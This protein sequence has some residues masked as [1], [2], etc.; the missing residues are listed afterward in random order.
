[1]STLLRAWRVVCRARGRPWADG[2]DCTKGPIPSST[3]HSSPLPESDITTFQMVGV[4]GFRH[5]HVRRHLGHPR[6]RERRLPRGAPRHPNIVAMPPGGGDGGGGGDCDALVNPANEALQGTRFDPTEANARF[7]NSGGRVY[8]EQ[9]GRAVTAG[10]AA[11]Y[12]ACQAV[13]EIPSTG[14]GVRCPVG[15]AVVTPARRVAQRIQ[16]RRPRR[17]SQARRL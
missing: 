4:N 12:Q 14:S 11:M 1:M 5:E 6:G 8:P 17:A 3:T 9:S 2:K 16:S 7:P 13:R 15:A 10:G